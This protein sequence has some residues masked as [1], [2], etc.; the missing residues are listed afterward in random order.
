MDRKWMTSSDRKWSKSSIEVAILTVFGRRF[1]GTVAVDR[2]YFLPVDRPCLVLQQ[3]NGK[4]C[5]NMLSYWWKRGL[6]LAKIDFWLWFFSSNIQAAPRM[7]GLNRARYRQTDC[8]VY[9]ETPYGD[10]EKPEIDDVTW[11]EVGQ[12]GVQTSK[13]LENN[14]KNVGPRQSLGLQALPALS[15]SVSDIFD[16]SISHW[17]PKIRGFKNPSI[18]ICRV[19][20]HFGRQ[21]ARNLEYEIG[22]NSTVWRVCSRHTI[23]CANTFLLLYVQRRCQLLKFTPIEFIEF[24]QK[25][26]INVSQ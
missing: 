20:V 17:V 15:R 3:S 26:L 25:M 9:E 14:A 19:F 7:P 12:I 6:K 24:S 5:W 16:R 22:L 13:M 21:I 1:L 2:R 23:A 18:T 8:R 4:C 11:P 10:P